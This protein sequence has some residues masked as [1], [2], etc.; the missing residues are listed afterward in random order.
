MNEELPFLGQSKLALII[1]FVCVVHMTSIIAFLFV[2]F[3]SIHSPN[4]QSTN[5][6]E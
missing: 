4:N 5:K 1:F 6:D 3:L 2:C